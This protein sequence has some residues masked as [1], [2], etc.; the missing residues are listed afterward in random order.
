MSETIIANSHSIAVRNDYLRSFL[1][2]MPNPHKLILSAH[3]SQLTRG[4]MFEIISLVKRFTNFT[5][6]NDP[7]KERDFGRVVFCD[8]VFLWKFDYF[9]ES[10]TSFQ[11]NGIRALTIMHESEY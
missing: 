5:N 10:F 2:M 4:E 8:E 6:E 7:Y 3:V 1:P 11:E 9:D